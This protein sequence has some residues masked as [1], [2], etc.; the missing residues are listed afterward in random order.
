MEDYL[1]MY[2]ENFEASAS[3]IILSQL[4]GTSDC[5]DYP[6]TKI[7][8]LRVWITDTDLLGL[9]N[10]YGC[11]HD[12]IMLHSYSIMSHVFFLLLWEVSFYDRVEGV[13]Q[14]LEIKISFYTTADVSYWNVSCC[15]YV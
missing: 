9:E 12:S 2:S 4:I 10:E 5:I 8:Q 3:V 1:S 6:F 14:L 15:A 11:K 7:W 13:E